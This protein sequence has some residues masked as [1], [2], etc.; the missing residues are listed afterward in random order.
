MELKLL[1]G[2]N[3]SVE[4][5][6]NGTSNHEPYLYGPVKAENN[7]VNISKCFSPS[8]P[9]GYY[10]YCVFESSDSSHRCIAK[11]STNVTN[12]KRV[13]LLDF[14]QLNSQY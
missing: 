9:N 11:S 2:S 13:H 1:K 12:G 14:K 5:E 8:L 4:I 10:D 3:T 7:M 6:F